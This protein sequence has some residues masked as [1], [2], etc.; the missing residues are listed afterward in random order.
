MELVVVLCRL[1]SRAP[2]LRHSARERLSRTGPR[3]DAHGRRRD[4]RRRGGGE[5]GSAWHACSLTGKGALEAL[6]RTGGFD[7][8]PADRQTR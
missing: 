5:P 7:L 3:A 1:I 4:R 8:G 2:P 6:P